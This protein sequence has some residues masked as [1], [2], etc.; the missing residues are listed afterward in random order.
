MDI[1]GTPNVCRIIACWTILCNI[2]PSS[3]GPGSRGLR[4]GSLGLGFRFYS[5]GLGV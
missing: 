1:Y 4:G 5:L 2:S 3:G